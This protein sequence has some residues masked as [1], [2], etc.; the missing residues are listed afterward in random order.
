MLHFRFRSDGNQGARPRGLRRAFGALA[1]AGAL[2][3]GCTTS[4]FDF[5]T[6][7]QNRGPAQAASDEVLGTGTVKVALLLPQSATGNAGALAA[8]LRNAAALALQEFQGADIQVLVKDDRGTADGARAAASEAISQGATLILGPLFAQ[9]VPGAAQVARAA[10]VPVIAFS[11]DTSTA[12]PGV[13]LLSFLP[14]S[15]V[16]RII[17]Y[18]ASKGKRSFAALLP[19]NAYGRVVEAALQQTVARV[20]GRVVAVERYALDRDAMQAKAEAVARLAQ[21]GSAD[22]IFMPD[23]GDAVPFLAGVLAANNV[24]SAR[25]QY[26]GS[27]QWSDSRI[28]QD[29]NLAGGWYPGPVQTEFDAFVARYRAAF[30]AAPF[31]TASLGYDA[32]ILAAGL[33]ANFGAQRFAPATITNA[34]GYRGMD[35]AFRFRPDGTNQRGL[36][37]YGVTR[38]GSQV[39]DPAPSGFTG[40][41]F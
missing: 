41:G 37:V 9:S 19:D 16:D 21:A 4:G 32:T 36:A 31:R 7:N 35:G 14:Q 20:G 33:T 34:N 2:L 39:V 13:Y 38:G 8:N 10:G 12:G 25:I 22:A 5:G 27:S 3:A 15:D 30:G 28:L 24:S 6:S 29:P 11:T 23:A 1:V 26:L 17:S 18:A 40:A